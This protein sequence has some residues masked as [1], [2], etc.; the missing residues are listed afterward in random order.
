MYP[1]ISPQI[2]PGGNGEVLYLPMDEGT[3]RKVYDAS[4]KGNTGTLV[5]GTTWVIGA[6]GNGFGLGFDGSSQYIDLGNSP[7]LNPTTVFT[8]SAWVFETAVSSSSS[9]RMVF[10]R[11]LSLAFGIAGSANQF[12]TS[13][14]NGSWNDYYSGYVV[15][16]STWKHIL[17]TRDV[18]G[19][20]KFYVDGKLVYS[21]SGVAISASNTS[22][23]NIGRDPSSA[24]YYQ[25]TIAEVRIYNRALSAQE[26]RRLYEQ[27]RF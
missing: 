1:L 19:N 8:I 17:T 4:G 9:F 21:F 3:G 5:N 18:S 10:E 14:N 6:K 16:L 26:I 7:M 2:Q 11:E 15:P 23:S 27:P 20:L 25:G 22:P 12:Y 24:H 13:I